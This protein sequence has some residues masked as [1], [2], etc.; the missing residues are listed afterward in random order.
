MLH[1]VLFAQH[2]L[3]KFSRLQCKGMGIEVYNKGRGTEGYNK[4]RG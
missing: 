4:G 2:K 3:A 1:K